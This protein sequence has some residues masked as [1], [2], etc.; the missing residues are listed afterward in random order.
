MAVPKRRVAYRGPIFNVE[1]WGLPRTGTKFA[2]ITGPDAVAVLP[3]LDD[4]R[5]LL[6]RQ[7]RHPL[8]RY[9]YEIP[10]GHIDPG[11]G[12]A[13]AARRELAEETGYVARMLTRLFGIYEAP[14]SLTQ[15]LHVYLAQNLEKRKAH[16]EQDEIIMLRKV[17]IKEALSMIRANKIRDAKTVCGILY[18]SKFVKK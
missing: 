12:P 11:E 17:S 1:E 5:I 6:E 10:A 9:L 3:I 18:Y 8:D 14:G 4:G 16:T 7:Y 15:F 13:H 2:R